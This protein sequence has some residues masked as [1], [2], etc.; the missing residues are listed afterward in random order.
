[1]SELPAKGLMLGIYLKDLLQ[2]LIFSVRSIKAFQL[3]LNSNS[4]ASISLG[5]LLSAAGPIRLCSGSY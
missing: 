2:K 1:M 5:V 3:L 4:M